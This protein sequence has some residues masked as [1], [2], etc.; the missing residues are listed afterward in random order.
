MARIEKQNPP[1]EDKT[2][3]PKTPIILGGI[4]ETLCYEQAKTLKNIDDVVVGS[5]DNFNPILKKYNINIELNSNFENFPYPDYSFYKNKEYVALKTS[6][7]C[8]FKCNYCA[9]YILNNSTYITK[10]PLV[11][12]NEIYKL[13]E[14][15]IQN[16]VFYDDALIFNSD[17][18]MK[19]LL[20]ELQKDNKKYYFHTPNGLH[21]RFLDQELA[22]LMFSAKF[23]QPRFSL[24]TSNSQEQKN[25]NNK[26]NNSEYERTIKYL[27]NAGYKKGEY[28]TYLLMG[29]PEQNIGNIKESI[30]YVHNLG[31]KI[32]LSEYSPI[33]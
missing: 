31:S 28:I 32:S 22:D 11:I 30:K 26:V 18:L 1:D 20:K 23:I 25:S 4:Y 12:K 3:F 29:M 27:Q 16:V 21:A 7:G 10:N 8:P 15:K 33:P 9:Q 5:F 17:K 14:N 2:I 13:T 6:I 19:V 24:E